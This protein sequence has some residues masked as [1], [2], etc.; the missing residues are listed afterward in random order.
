MRGDGTVRHVLSHSRLEGPPGHYDFYGVLT[1]VTERR[2]A[3]AALHQA[4]ERAA[5]ATRGAG[6]GT[7]E[8]DL[9]TGQSYW[10]EQMWRLRGLSPRAAPLSVEERMAL[11][12]PD[13]R[14]ATLREL[15]RATAE[16]RLSNLEF[17]VR[18]PDGQWRWIA[19]RSTAVRDEHGQPTRR[20][21]VN[22]DVTDMR[23]A[24]VGARG[25]GR[26]AAREPGQV[27]VPVAHEP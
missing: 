27:A 18:W 14:E 21:G 1:D 25:E 10:D 17:R 7:W 15:D 12:H 23:S 9:I 24:A 2:A 19:S 16:G 6:M 3:E 5:L 4:S 26:G 13:D 20:I 11:V 8:Q 22:W